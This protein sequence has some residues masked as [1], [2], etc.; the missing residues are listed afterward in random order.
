MKPQA[1]VAE[2]NKLIEAEELDRENIFIEWRSKAASILR[3]VL[4]ASAVQVREFVLMSRPT[5]SGYT[6]GNRRKDQEFQR[7]DAAQRG[8]AVLRSVAYNLEVVTA[9]HGPLDDTTIDPELWSHVEGLIADSDWSKVPAE[10]VIFLEHKIRVWAGEPTAKDG[11]AMTGKTLFATAFKDDGPLRL[12][13]QSSE[14]EGWRGL[15]TGLAQA[16]GNVAR[17]RIQQ[18]DDLRRYAMGVLGLG[19]LI[20]TQLRYEHPAEIQQAEAEG[21]G[22]GNTPTT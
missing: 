15:G 8:K 1:A 17:H 4:G 13:Q 9:E 7:A 6:T 14:Y 21:A 11:A 12:G 20:L 16:I 3:A 22:P 18:R 2:L 10:V 5:S 19:S